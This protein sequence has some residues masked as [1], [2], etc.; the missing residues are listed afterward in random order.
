MNVSARFSC[1]ISDG[2]K[3]NI[4]NTICMQKLIP[5]IDIA[6]PIPTNPPSNQPIK[7]AVPSTIPL[8]NPTDNFVYLLIATIKLS[9]GPAP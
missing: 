4:E 5:N 9:R 2:S 1:S 6:V 7:S 8:L 3:F